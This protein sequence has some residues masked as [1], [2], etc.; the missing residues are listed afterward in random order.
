MATYANV[1]VN[2]IRAWLQDIIL[3]RDVKWLEDV[4]RECLPNNHYILQ[5]LWG[6]NGPFSISI[7]HRVIFFDN[8]SAHRQLRSDCITV[9]CLLKIASNGLGVIYNID[10]ILSRKQ[11]GKPPQWSQFFVWVVVAE[12]FSFGALTTEAWNIRSRGNCLRE[13]SDKHSYDLDSKLNNLTVYST[14]L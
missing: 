10:I 7:F 13:T 5:R 2:K 14:M 12:L 9:I 11:L 1:R 3:S 6:D 8:H 4:T